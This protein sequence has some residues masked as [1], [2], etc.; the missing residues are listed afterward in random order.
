MLYESA[1]LPTELQRLGAVIV[2][3]YAIGLHF[4]LMGKRLV[5]WKRLSFVFPARIL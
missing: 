4:S 1:A 2:E 5:H 3:Y